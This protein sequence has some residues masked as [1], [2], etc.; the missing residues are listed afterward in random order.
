MSIFDV[1]AAAE[2]T[3]A[4]GAR[5]VRQVLNRAVNQIEQSLKRV[6]EVVSQFGR[7][8]LAAELGDD[9]PAMLAVYQALKTAVED[10]SVG[11]QV[12]DLP[13]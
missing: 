5:Q 1:P 11:K 2:P 9:A 7:S 12:D 6:R 4:D 8:D 3:A 10:E 13:E